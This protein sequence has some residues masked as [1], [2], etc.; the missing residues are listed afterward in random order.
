MDSPDDKSG[1]EK[2]KSRWMVLCCTPS[3]PR[4]LKHKPATTSDA[5]IKR[6]VQEILK[7]YSVPYSVGSTCSP[8]P[9]FWFWSSR[10]ACR[11]VACCPGVT[12]Q[13]RDANTPPV[14]SPCL[15]R[16]TIAPSQVLHSLLA[17]TER[18]QG[19]VGPHSS[20][21]ETTYI[22]YQRRR[23][24]GR[25]QTLPSS[26]NTRLCPGIVAHVD[27]P[28]IRKGSSLSSSSSLTLPLAA[29]G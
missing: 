25:L 15:N 27:S 9:T 14:R 7:A 22:T 29:C 18:V 4:C 21:L 5:F 11:A 28:L 8:S 10:C 12:V 16:S 6:Y 13:P 3:L 26:S 2:D 17:M 20:Q 1:A 23:T 24:S 19:Q